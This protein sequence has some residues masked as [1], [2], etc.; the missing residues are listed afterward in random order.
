M[1]SPIDY[2]SNH[3]A[4][5]FQE[6]H[7]ERFLAILGD[8]ASLQGKNEEEDECTLPPRIVFSRSAIFRATA[9]IW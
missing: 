4:R 7:E 6:V 9:R 2:Q 1:G 3:T 8:T 5:S